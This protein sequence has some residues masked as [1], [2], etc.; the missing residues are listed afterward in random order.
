[1]DN[2]GAILQEIENKLRNEYNILEVKD[3]NYGR[4]FKIKVNNDSLNFRIFYNKKGNI[5]FDYSTIN[6]SLFLSKL[7]SFLEGNETK[8]KNENVI[9]DIEDNEKVNSFKNAI[10]TDE[11]GK[12]DYF[13]PLVVA[14][15]YVDAKTKVILDNNGVRDSKKI[16]DKK[17]LELAQMIKRICVNQYVIVEIAPLTY[18]NLYDTF[19][20][21]GKNL[22]NL[23]AWGHAKA[24]EEVLTKVDCELAISDKFA[25]ERFI[26]SKLQEK[27]REVT[28]KQEHKA[29]KYTSVAAASILARARFL[30]KI[31]KLSI[32]YGMKLSKGVS[33]EVVNQ[34][35]SLIENY[36]TDVLKNVAKLHFKTTDKVLN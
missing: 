20:K 21:E 22:N 33:E 3:I 10:G 1:M 30:E 29:E 13:G 5:K 11:S 14:G 27:G 32:E 25:D 6:D 9:N 28:L 36:N 34:A 4:Q 7:S 12:G 31:N 8:V 35:R 18:N 23:L 16:G 19:K 24:I 17:I 2:V 15:V 26:I